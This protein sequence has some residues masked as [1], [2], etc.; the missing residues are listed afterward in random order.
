MATDDSGRVLAFLTWVASDRETAEITWIAVSADQRRRGHGRS[1][2]EALA[3][4]LSRQGVRFLLVKTLSARD[5]D[6]SYEQ[7]RAFYRS[8]GFEPVAELDIW[9]PQNPAQLMMR[10]L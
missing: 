1:M 7:T 9:G 4:R 2:I 10:L 6:E 3:E 5:P 8:Q